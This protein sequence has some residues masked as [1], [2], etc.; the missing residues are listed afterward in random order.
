MQASVIKKTLI[1]FWF[2]LL[3]AGLNSVMAFMDMNMLFLVFLLFFLVQIIIPKFAVIFN[4]ILT[5]VIMHRRFYIGN[6]FDYRW[7]LWLAEDVGKDLKVISQNGF[8]VVAP[9]SAM[10][11]AMGALIL[12]QMLFSRMFYKG[13][14]V[15]LFLCFGTAVLAAMHLW[16]GKGSAWYPFFFAILGLIIKA[17]MPLEMHRSFPLGRWFGI[18]TVWVVILIAVAGALPSPSLDLSSWLQWGDGWGG[19]GTFPGRAI[20]G[21]SSFDGALGGPLRESETPALLVTSPAPVY[22]KGETRDIYTGRS[23]QPTKMRDLPSEPL[24]P[25]G[26]KGTPVEITIQVLSDGAETVFVP[27]YPLRIDTTGGRYITQLPLGYIPD[28]FQYEYYTFR[29][30]FKGDDIYTL[31]VVLPADDPDHLRQ[32]T[33]SGAAPRYYDLENVPDR[34]QEMARSV[35][36]EIGNSYDKAVA[37]ASYLRY[38]WRYSLDTLAPPPDTDFVEDFLFSR[39][40]GYCVHFSTAFVVMARSVGLP[41][42]WV[43]GYSYGIQ[44]EPGKYLVRNSHAHS[45]AEV[46]FDDYGWVPFEATPGGPHLRQEAGVPNPEQGGPTDPAVPDPSK[47]KPDPEPGQEDNDPNPGYFQG[48]TLYLTIGAALLLLLSVL[49][50]RGLGRGAIE[51][52]YARLQKRLRLFGWA[53]KKWETPRE[54]L[55]RVD[56]LPD[57]PKLNK[58]VHGFEDSVYGGLP[59]PEG[60]KQSLGKRYTL[61]GLLIHRLFQTKEQ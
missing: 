1:G 55:L 15:T 8:T 30:N 18:L 35:V 37:L 54:H 2:F 59:D 36:A 57:R 58:F 40:T 23:W 42:R 24:P 10:A 7:F 52:V 12:L 9:V 43:K 27:R 45:W 19:R 48:W 61:F 13:K 14:G 17:T 50:F 39:Q 20:M 28:G 47:P 46:W 6:F 44:E 33:T 31:T 5:L 56:R 26:L 21:Y 34:V 3:F 4:L 22:L 16:Q 38:G 51:E 41:A 32:L 11:L 53:R 25:V 60:E 29:K 49:L